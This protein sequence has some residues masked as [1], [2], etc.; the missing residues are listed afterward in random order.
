MRIIRFIY[1]LFLAF[2]IDF[3]K[4]INIIRGFPWYVSD[5]IK[6]K[7]Q[8]KNNH[9]FNK[10]EFLPALNEK[11]QAAGEVKGHYFH[12]DLLVAQ[13]IFDNNPLVHIDIGSRLDGFVAHVASFRKITVLDV[14]DLK[15]TTE[16]I[17]FQQLD[18]MDDPSIDWVESCD[19]LSCLHALE[20]FGL[21]RYSDPINYDGHLVGLTNMIQFLKPGGVFYLS[22]PIGF[23]RIVFNAHRVFSVGY[24]VNQLN[25]SFD[26][27]SFSY[28]D[29]NGDLHKNIPLDEIDLENSFNCAY[30]CGIFEFIKNK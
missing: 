28:V 11:Y 17:Y 20:H 30:G 7:A 8:K 5:Y 24:V 10:V 12:Q 13:K 6:F 3:R 21:G 2:G 15:Q 19:S 18:L 23:Q 27:N 16:N 22:V 1:F 26:L 29:D 4:M 25:E 9:S 14:R